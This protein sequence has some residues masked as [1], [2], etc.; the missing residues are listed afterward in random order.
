MFKALKYVSPKMII[1]SLLLTIIT[2][3]LLM[4][5]FFGTL[6][7]DK[8]YSLDTAMYY[9]EATFHHYLQMQGEEGRQ[10]Y[11]WVH[12]MDYGF[13][14]SL[15]SFMFSLLAYLQMRTGNR[16]FSYF[17]CFPVIY[18]ICDFLEGITIDLSILLYPARIPILA[19]SCGVFT[20]VKMSAVYATG[21]IIVIFGLMA[22]LQKKKTGR[23]VGSLS[24]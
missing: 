18:L 14:L 4:T 11:L 15:F 6:P 20:L 9:N 10:A 1:I 7:M 13:M 19:P 22:V 5:S 3:T 2:A 21:V 23:D 12:L 8:D 24:R 16:Q 17:L